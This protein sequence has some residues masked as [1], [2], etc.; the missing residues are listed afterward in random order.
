MKISDDFWTFVYLEFVTK[1][2]EFCVSVLQAASS[3]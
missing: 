3:L 2:I 1:E